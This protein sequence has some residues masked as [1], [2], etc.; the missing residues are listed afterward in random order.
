M[1]PNLTTLSPSSASQTKAG[2]VDLGLYALSRGDS[3]I[4]I[5]ITQLIQSR[6]WSHE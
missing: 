2:L 3:L 4:V 5:T 1:M 6:G